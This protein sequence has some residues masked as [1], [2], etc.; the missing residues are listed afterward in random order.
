MASPF[1]V[2]VDPTGRFAYAANL[3]TSDVSAFTINGATG[4]LTLIWSVSD[5]LNGL[6]A[7]PNLIAVIGSLPLLRRLVKEF[8]AKQIT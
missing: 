2:T 8:F 5:T 7:I 6:M 1:S 3:G 4:A